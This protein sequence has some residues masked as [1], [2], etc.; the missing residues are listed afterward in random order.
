MTTVQ[1]PLFDRPRK[2][3]PRVPLRELVLDTISRLGPITDD[4]LCRALRPKPANSIRPRRIE[5]AAMGLILKVGV[6]TR[7]GRRG[8][9]L[10]DVPREAAR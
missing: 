2:H 4:G 5:L 3:T 8:C 1:I 9:T 10:W 7:P 6:E